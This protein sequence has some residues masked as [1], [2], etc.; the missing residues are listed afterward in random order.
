MEKNGEKMEKKME[1]IMEKNGG[2]MGKKWKKMVKKWGKN[3]K[4]KQE[5]TT[6]CRS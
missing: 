6:E 4:I 3:G 1:K 5:I 2:E